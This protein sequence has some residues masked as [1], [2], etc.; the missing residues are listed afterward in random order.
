MSA[1]A[2]A[3]QA[4]AIALAVREY[5]ARLLR[6]LASEHTRI[7][8]VTILET[9]APTAE[10]EALARD[11]AANLERIADAAREEAERIADDAREEAEREAESEAERLEKERDQERERAEKAE[12]ELAD[13]RRKAYELGR[14]DERASKGEP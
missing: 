7:H 14:A 13:L 12:A 4:E 5:H 11:I 6:A 8:D 9:K 3:E 1:Q 10:C 2:Q